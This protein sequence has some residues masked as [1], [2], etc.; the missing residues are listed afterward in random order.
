MNIDTLLLAPC[1]HVMAPEVKQMRNVAA[2]AFATAALLG[3]VG[4]SARQ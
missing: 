3:R 2:R 4:G 1:A